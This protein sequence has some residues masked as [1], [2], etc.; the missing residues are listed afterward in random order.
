MTSSNRWFA[1]SLFLLSSLVLASGTRGQAPATPE[2]PPAL[3]FWAR[4]QTQLFA[5]GE[6]VV[7]VISIYTRSAEFLLVVL[8]VMN[9]WI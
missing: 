8:P 9:L 2:T 1:T 5:Q 3:F 6:P 4:P 7:L